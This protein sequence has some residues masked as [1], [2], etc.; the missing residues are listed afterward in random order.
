MSNN[1]FFNT[2]FKYNSTTPADQVT[3]E[4]SNIYKYCRS[5]LRNGGKS[6]CLNS[7]GSMSFTRVPI[8]PLSKINGL[9]TSTNDSTI[10][11]KMRYAQVV[12]TAFPAQSSTS[13]A[14]KQTC[15]LTG[16]SRYYK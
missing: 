13:A 15:F 10:T 2:G 7:S 5:P 9:G 3:F 16:F 8:K 14:T 11:C 1:Y 4:N 12:R 6:A